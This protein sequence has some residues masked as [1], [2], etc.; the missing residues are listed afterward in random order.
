MNACALL[1]K[2]HVKL[3]FKDKTLFFTSLLTPM[4][5]LVLFVTFLRSVYED[6]LMSVLAAVPMAAMPSKDVVDAFTGSWLFSSI[7]G[8]SSVTVAFCSNITMVQDKMNGSRTDMLVTPVRQRTLAVS[9][10]VA[11]LLTTGLVCLIALAAGLVYLA[12]VGWYLSAADILL[13]AADTG[14][15]IL[16]GTALAALTEQ[17]LSTQ[18]GVSAVATLVSSMY[19]FLCGAYM[20]ISQFAPAIRHFVAFIPGTY[21]TVLLRQ[22]L[23]RGA[24]DELAKSVP[25]QAIDALRDGFDN[26]LYFFDTKVADWQMYAVLLGAAAVLLGA[27]VLTSA[28]R[29]KKR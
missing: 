12:S 1:I 4:I 17:F 29:G 18:G 11:N 15:C 9:Y 26:N 3:Y 10:Y 20:P 8:V 2:R 5:L 25:A 27:Y 19:G 14:C 28:L 23:M 13:T 24:I 6:S 16:F 7:L 21:G 22:H